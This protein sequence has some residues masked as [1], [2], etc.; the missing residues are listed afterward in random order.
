MLLHKADDGVHPLR[1]IAD[2]GAFLGAQLCGGIRPYQIP[3]TLRCAK[4]GTVG[5]QMTG[6]RRPAKWI[7]DHDSWR[8]HQTGGLAGHERLLVLITFP[9]SSRPAFGRASSLPSEHDYWF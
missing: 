5:E 7:M 2:I 1:G 6:Q 3:E 9:Y 4:F 8:S